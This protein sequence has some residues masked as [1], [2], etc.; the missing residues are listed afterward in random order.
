MRKME[1]N[2]PQNQLLF[3]I[4]LCFKGTYKNT[5]YESNKKNIPYSVY[6]YPFDCHGRLCS[7]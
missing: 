5:Y 4:R 7:N 2:L 3:V 1:F 6:N